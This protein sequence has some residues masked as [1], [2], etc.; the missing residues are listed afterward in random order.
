QSHQTSDMSQLCAG[1]IINDLYIL[2]A[3]HCTFKNTCQIPYVPQDLTVTVADHNIHSLNKGLIGITQSFTVKEIIRHENYCKSGKTIDNDIA[4]LKLAK[5]MDL[6]NLKEVGMICLPDNPVSEYDHAYA[7][8]VEQKLTSDEEDKLF[9]SELNGV[10]LIKFPNCALYPFPSH[11]TEN[12][13]CAVYKTDTRDTCGGDS[14]GPLYIIE[15]DSRYIQIGI[16]SFGPPGSKCA[17]LGVYTDIYKF[18]SWI[19]EKSQDGTCG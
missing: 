7:T 14:G 5:R 13:F 3:G 4:L 19:R 10:E 16:V 11:I 18:L 12:M 8:A 1:S 2:T 6:M 15:N 17:G 9:T